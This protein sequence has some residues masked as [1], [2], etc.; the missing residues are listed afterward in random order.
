MTHRYFSFLFAVALILCFANSQSTNAQVSKVEPENL[1]QGTKIAITYN[2]KAEGAKLSAGDDIYVSTMSAAADGSIKT[3]VGKMEKA[4]DLFKYEIALA[5][6]L[7]SIQIE[8][9]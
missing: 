3:F 9:V 7:H 4:G 1:T 8:F 5:P 6:N 2:P